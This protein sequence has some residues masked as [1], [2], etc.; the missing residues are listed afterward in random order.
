M[1]TISGTRNMTPQMIVEEPSHLA[2]GIDLDE[3]DLLAEGASRMR[4]RPRPKTTAK[5]SDFEQ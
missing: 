2:S 3:T 5:R 1:Q 4:N